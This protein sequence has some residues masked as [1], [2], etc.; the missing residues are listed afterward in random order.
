MNADCRQAYPEP[1]SDRHV[2]GLHARPRSTL[3]VRASTCATADRDRRLLLLHGNPLT[4]VMWHKIAPR[5]A[6]HFTGRGRGPARLR[7]QLKAGRRRRPHRLLVP[8]HGAGSGRSDV[9]AGLR[10]IRCLRP[11]PRRARR[12]SHGARSSRGGYEKVAFL[13]IVP[14]HH[15]LNNIKKQWAVD[16]YHW[17]FMAQPYD[18]P[19]A[20]ADRLRPRALHPEEAG[21]ERRGHERLHARGAGRV[22]SMLHAREHSCGVRGLPRRGRDR[23][24]SRRSRPRDQAADADARAMGRAEPRQPQLPSDRGMAASALSTCAEECCL[25]ALPAEQVPDETS[26]GV[27][28]LLT[29]TA[30][31]RA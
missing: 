1:L 20:D 30:F 4:H 6:E 13:D 29:G 16:S 5:L 25:A 28:S 7:R 21:Q 8:R 17:F 10:L 15:V 24:R 27:A 9:G 2:R 3:P 31:E 22:H 11:R 26:C 23:P 12:A 19:G 14:T 18:Y